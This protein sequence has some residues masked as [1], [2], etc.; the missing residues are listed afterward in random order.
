MQY[1]NKEKIMG[2][3]REK[4]LNYVTRFFLFRILAYISIMQPTINTF[5]KNLINYYNIY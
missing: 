4:V 2:G 3:E 5:K 1:R